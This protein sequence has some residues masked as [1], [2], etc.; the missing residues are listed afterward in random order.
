MSD[1]HWFVDGRLVSYLISVKSNFVPRGQKLE[2]IS[3]RPT[4]MWL[5]FD[6]QHVIRFHRCFLIKKSMLRLCLHAMMLDILILF[7]DNRRLVRR[8]N[9]ATYYWSPSACFYSDRPLI[10]L[11]TVTQSHHIPS[12]VASNSDWVWLEEKTYPPWKRLSIRE[13]FLSK[14]DSFY[15]Y[16]STVLQHE[17]GRPVIV[18]IIRT[19][20]GQT[21]P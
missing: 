9:T 1:D 10:F 15:F 3:Y 18:G 8:Q 19:R 17:L 2:S 12:Y 7:C 16:R 21:S 14:P 5:W 20:W 4:F 13:Y 6:F 11:W